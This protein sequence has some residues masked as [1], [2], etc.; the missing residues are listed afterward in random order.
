[1][2]PCCEYFGTGTGEEREW[3]R[4]YKSRPKLRSS[5]LLALCFVAWVRRIHVWFPGWCAKQM[6]GH[7][8]VK[9]TNKY[10]NILLSVECEILR[11]RRVWLADSSMPWRFLWKHLG[12]LRRQLNRADGAKCQTVSSGTCM[13]F[14]SNHTDIIHCPLCFMLARAKPIITRQLWIMLSVSSFLPGATGQP[15]LGSKR[16][17][18]E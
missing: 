7:K 17:K 13:V 3:R 2:K 11:V 5:A 18:G 1:M 15:I 4:Y 10:N 6:P 12:K 14:V 16:S 9:Q 8:A